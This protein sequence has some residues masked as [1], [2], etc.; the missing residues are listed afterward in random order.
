MNRWR[1]EKPKRTRE[2]WIGEMDRVHCLVHFPVAEMR[3][4]SE[5]RIACIVWCISPSL[6]REMDRRNGSRA[7]FGAFPRSETGNGSEKRMHCLAHFLVAE[8]GNGSEKWIACIVWCISSLLRREMDRR[9]GSRA[10][11]GAFRVLRR[12]MDQG[13]GS[14][15][16]FGAFPASAGSRS[17]GIGK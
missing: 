15:A 8:T 13:N 14:R 7:L 6:R 4:G 11:F 10:L 1:W 3:N 16:L 17:G 12:E 9:N 5:K 2:Q